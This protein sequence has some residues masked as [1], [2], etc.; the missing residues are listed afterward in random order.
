MTWLGTSGNMNQ[1]NNADSFQS[2]P[3]ACPSLNDLATGTDKTLFENYGAVSNFHRIHC[4]TK[5]C[6]FETESNFDND[7]FCHEVNEKILPILLEVWAVQNC[8][9]HN[10]LRDLGYF[11]CCINYILICQKIQEHHFL[12]LM[13]LQL[14]ILLVVSIIILV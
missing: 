14:I 8:I 5:D 13:S 11:V 10:A 6:Q 12:C 2:N 3:V 1:T 7:N 4:K 9:T